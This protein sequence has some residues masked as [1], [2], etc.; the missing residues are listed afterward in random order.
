M[1]R[2]TRRLDEASGE[3]MA[4]V[5]FW[6][7]QVVTFWQPFRVPVRAAGS[8]RCSESSEKPDKLALRRDVLAGARRAL[9]RLVAE[10]DAIDA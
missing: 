7:T 5:T 9:F 3:A 8:V 10:D 4:R 2:S 6:V 1:C